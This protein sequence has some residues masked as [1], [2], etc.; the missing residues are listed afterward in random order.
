MPVVSCI[1][2]GGDGPDILK[3]TSRLLMKRQTV[4]ASGDP[5]SYTGPNPSL[6]AMIRF[7]ISVV[8]AKM[9]GLRVFRMRRLMR[10]SSLA[11]ASP[12]TP[13]VTFKYDLI[14]LSF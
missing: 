11:M 7:M 2:M 13:L 14:D 9:E 5:K 10:N 6:R 1:L 4:T 3:T 12:T 8:P